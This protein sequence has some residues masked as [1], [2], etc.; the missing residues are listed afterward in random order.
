MLYLYICIYNTTSYESYARS[1]DNIMHTSY[2]SIIITSS[3]YYYYYYIYMR[4]IYYELVRMHT[5]AGPK[6]PNLVLTYSL[7]SSSC[8]RRFCCAS[9]R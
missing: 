5:T 1:M 9:E 4:V 8:S 2:E 3:Y 7:L 6:T